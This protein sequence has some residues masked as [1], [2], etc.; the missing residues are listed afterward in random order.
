MHES[1]PAGKANPTS[2]SEPPARSSE[3]EAHWN[4]QLKKVAKAKPDPEKAE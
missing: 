2:S 3:D 4:E 1:H